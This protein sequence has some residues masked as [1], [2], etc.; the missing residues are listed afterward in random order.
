MDIPTYSGIIR[1][2]QAYS[3]PCV[4]LAYS[5]VWHTKNQYDVQNSDLFRTL[6]YQSLVIF[7]TR[8]IFR[9]LSSSYDLAS[10]ENS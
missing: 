1:H 5:E 2:N 7:R 3:E 8:G 6:V 10:C 4:T 9:T